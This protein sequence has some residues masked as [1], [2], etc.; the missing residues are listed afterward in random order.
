MGTELSRRDL[1]KLL[2][3]TA[4]ALW[5]PRSGDAWTIPAPLTEAPTARDERFW[6]SREHYCHGRNSSERGDQHY[7]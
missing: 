2:G 5:L 7:V 1:V 4:A 3:G 6:A